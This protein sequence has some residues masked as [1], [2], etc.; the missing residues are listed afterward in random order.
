MLKILLP[1]SVGLVIGAAVA[2]VYWRYSDQ[3]DSELNRI[4]RDIRISDHILGTV[5]VY[6]HQGIQADTICGAE[7]YANALGT[8]KEGFEN[9]PM[10]SA[11]KEH[12]LTLMQTRIASLR[13]VVEKYSSTNAGYDYGNCFR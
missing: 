12:Y 1:V 8:H 5:Q 9:I 2:T 3:L 7:L 4:E 11:A 6:D 13:E 10:D